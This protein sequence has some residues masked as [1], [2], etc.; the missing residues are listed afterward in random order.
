MQ[1]DL[2]VTFI[3][4]KQGLFTGQGP[5]VCGEIILDSL[6]VPDRYLP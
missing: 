3:G 1:A 5:A 4:A 6:D 2:T